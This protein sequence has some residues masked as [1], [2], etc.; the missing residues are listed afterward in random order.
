MEEITVVRKRS[1]MW[2]ALLVILFLAVI[3][4]AVL[5][6]MGSDARTDVGWNGIIEFGRRSINGTA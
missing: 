4:L 1:Q 5:W 2:T 6:L 3:V